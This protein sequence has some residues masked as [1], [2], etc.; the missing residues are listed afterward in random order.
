MP[1]ES[2]ASDTCP[3]SRTTARYVPSPPSTTSASTPAS[4]IMRAA[5]NGSSTRAVT[6]MSRN[7][8]A[9]SAASG[10]CLRARWRSSMTFRPSGSGIIS[11]RATPHDASDDRSRSTIFTRSAS[12]RLFAF[13]MTRRMSR[14]ETGLAMM[15]TSGFA[16]ASMPV[17]PFSVFC[18]ADKSKRY[19]N[20]MRASGRDSGAK[21]RGNTRRNRVH[22]RGVRGAAVTGVTAAGVSASVQAYRACV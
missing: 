9:A 21:K 18:A 22:R 17:S 20:G 1:I 13:A 4:R 7:S 6:G 2:P 3:H 15:P 14:A 11:T 12:C 8:T 16:L 19:A 10:P 5:R